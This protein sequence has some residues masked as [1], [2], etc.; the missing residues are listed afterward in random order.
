MLDASLRWHD[1]KGDGEG[2]HGEGDGALGVAVRAGAVGL[3]REGRRG[4]SANSPS[5][6]MIRAETAFSSL[7]I[8]CSGRGGS[9]T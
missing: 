5:I 3:G 7:S 1:G 4:H 8:S 6:A 9:N 2:G